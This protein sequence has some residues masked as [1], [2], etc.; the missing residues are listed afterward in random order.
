[1][2]VQC[3]AIRKGTCSES[4]CTH[5]KA[6]DRED[7]TS[8]PMRSVHYYCTEWCTCEPLGIYVRCCRVKEEAL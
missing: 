7:R 5:A 1:M 2:T 3:N 6:H 4:S 8:G